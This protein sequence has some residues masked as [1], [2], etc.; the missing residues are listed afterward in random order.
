[1]VDAMILL[2]A[3]AIGFAWGRHDFVATVQAKEIPVGLHHHDRDLTRP[4]EFADRLITFLG[5]ASRLLACWTLA[6]LIVRLRPPRP[7]RARLLCQPGTLAVATAYAVAVAVGFVLA[8][9]IRAKYKPTWS[10]YAGQAINLQGTAQ[11]ITAAWL[12]L[13]FSGRWR[14]E[15][16]WADRLGCLIGLSWIALSAAGNMFD[17]R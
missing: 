4:V 11:A 7:R 9:L 5:G 12:I 17:W 2:A 16:T 1:L 15:P 10:D 13:A 8:F 6:V 3:T 14:R